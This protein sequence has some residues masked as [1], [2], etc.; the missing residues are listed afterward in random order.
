[1]KAPRAVALCENFC[2]HARFPGRALGRSGDAAP[3]GRRA[4]PSGR[5]RERRGALAAAARRAT[6]RA[7]RARGVADA[8][9]RRTRR[10]RARRDAL[11]LLDAD[12]CVARAQSSR[13]RRSR[14]GAVRASTKGS[15]RPRATGTAPRAARCSCPRRCASRSRGR[16]STRADV[17]AKRLE[18]VARRFA[19]RAWTAMAD[20]ARGRVLAA[21]GDARRGVR[22]L[23]AGARGVRRDRRSLRCGALRHGAEPAVR[24]RARRA[25]AQARDSAGRSGAQRASRRSARPSSRP[26][27]ARGK[28]R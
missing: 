7:R 26:D 2:G 9:R 20:Q 17:Y 13:R 19:S 4:L 28:A 3:Q 5:E 6:H 23:R 18:D 14:G 24:R 11:A 8:A 27:P 10:R 1:M 12:P 22:N 15:P 21:R 16:T 25:I